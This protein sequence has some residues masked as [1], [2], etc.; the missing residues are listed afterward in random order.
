MP[1]VPFLVAIPTI[2]TTMV[3]EDTR[4]ADAIT[5][6]GTIINLEEVATIV[7]IS[8]VQEDMAVEEVITKVEVVTTIVREADTKFS[9]RK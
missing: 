2:V 5:T 3:E 1:I 7:D 8:I 4:V 9:F 6:I